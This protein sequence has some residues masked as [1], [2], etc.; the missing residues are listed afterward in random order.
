MCGANGV[1]GSSNAV[2]VTGAK[3]ENLQGCC[4][5]QWILTPVDPGSY[6]YHVQP[7]IIVG[8]LVW[9]GPDNSTSQNLTG[10]AL[11]ER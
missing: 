5:H 8:P 7:L 9:P 10:D 3:L 11:K 4:G 2:A 6:S 1:C